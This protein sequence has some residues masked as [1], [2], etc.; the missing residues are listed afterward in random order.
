LSANL[1]IVESPAKAKTIKKYLGRE[2]EVLA[3]YGHVRDLVPKEG[4]VDPEHDFRMQYQLI[5]R[6][7][8]H[9]QAIARALRKAR[10]LYLATDPDR[11]GEA[12]AWH[13]YEILRE[14][15]ELDGKDVHRVAFYEITRNGIRQAIEEPRSLSQDL[16]N[17]QQ[18]RRALDYLVGFN[19]SPLLWK[20]V[21]RGLSAGRVQSPA[22]RMICEREEE[23][24]VFKPREYWTIDAE[25]EHSELEFPLKLIEFEGRKVEQ[26]SFTNTTEA[27]AVE[28]RLKAAAGG[29]LKVLEIDRKPR[30]R[31]PSPP[32]TTSTLQ[33][34]AAR[35]L[36]F[37]A[38]RT[39]R[40]AQQLYEGVDT[41]DGAVGLITYMRTDSVNLAGEAV[42]EIR[43]TIAK[44]YGKEAVAE[45]LRIYKT[46]SK[47][48]QEA[49]EAIRPTMPGVAPADVEGRMDADQ[50][51]LYSLIWKRAIACQMAHALYDTVAVDM[52][53]GPDGATRHLLR[54]NGSTLVKPGFMAVY[55]E[56]LDDAVE[57]SDRVLPAMQIGDA[58]KLLAV[59]PEQHFTEPPPRYSEASLVKALEEHGI[60][61]PSTYASIISTLKDRE[62]VEMDSRR[63]VPT[64]IGKIVNRFLTKNFHRYVEYGFTARME[65][66]LDAISR[67]E[68]E[69]V[70]LMHQ[71]WKPFIAQVEHTEKTVTREEVAQARDLG[72]DPVSGKPVSVRMGRFGPFVQMGT[73]DD[74]EKPRFAGLR[75]GQKMDKV[76]LADA[77]EL[78]KLPRTLGQTAE[79]EPIQTNI[80]RFGPYIKYGAKYVS[81]KEDDPYTVEL[82]R[83]LE[84]IEQKKIAD[85]NRIIRDFADEGIQVLNGRY[86]PYITDKTRNA[87]IPKER[88]PKSLT[89][90]EC[91]ELLAQAP[92]RRGR[93]GRAPAQAAAAPAPAPTPPAEAT[94][95]PPQPR[96]AAKKKTHHKA[97]AKTRSA[98]RSRKA[99]PQKPPVRRNSAAR[100]TR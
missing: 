72:K 41:G 93:R 53:A 68:D 63:F 6:N 95:A 82:P 26:F 35:K 3:S 25:G 99:A 34:E 87:K 9:V 24:A 54:A 86:G 52:L 17:A 47:N 64:D 10:S 22:L 1:V 37:S 81:L 73:K 97:R 46:K 44:L 29:H 4:A 28:H 57:E 60:G 94:A 75:P 98:A 91:K 69:W 88:D 48:A 20:K 71:F 51:R 16:I 77:M 96:A 31:N 58:V 19:L 66:A 90:E 79:G 50:H 55:H 74:E 12:I 59:H 42:Q 5:E 67:G 62:Y 2:F 70:P 84:L 61:R 14:R 30:R 27:H 15:G 18:A 85:A 49:H 89:L 8:R 23:I 33:Q 56:D 32:F 83:A 36:G 7:E 80:G 38:Q 100:S 13:L 43:A 65:D 78:F 11:E 39:M 21:R 92:L 40:L 76:T 45:E